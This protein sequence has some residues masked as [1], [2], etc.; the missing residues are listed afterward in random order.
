MF[1]VPIN[2]FSN[3]T[4]GIKFLFLVIKGHFIGNKTSLINKWNYLSG[5]SVKIETH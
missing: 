2:V 1:H 5:I 4:F 3:I